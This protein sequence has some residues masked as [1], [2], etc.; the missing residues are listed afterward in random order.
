MI[1]VSSVLLG[2]AVLVGETDNTRDR[3]PTPT[4]PDTLTW[5]DQRVIDML[6]IGCVRLA[7]EYEIEIDESALRA[8]LEDA[9][10]DPDAPS[11]STW[12]TFWL[13]VN[14]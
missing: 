7:L 8:M 11:R 9:L 6:A 12:E 10:V 2:L 3:P 4:S 1:G 13:W 5:A 14:S